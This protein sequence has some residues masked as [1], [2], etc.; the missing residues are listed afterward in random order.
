MIPEQSLTMQSNPNPHF[1]NFAH[2]GEKQRKIYMKREYIVV[3][4]AEK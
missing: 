3:G 4:L 2:K 1:Y